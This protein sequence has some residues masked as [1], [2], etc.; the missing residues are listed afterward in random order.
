V[1]SEVDPNGTVSLT[2]ALQAFSLVVGP[3]PGVTPPAGPVGQVADGTFA[4]RWV[5]GYW[6]QLSTAQRTAIRRY[7]PEVGRETSAG[8]DSNAWLTGYEENTPP[9]AGPYQAAAEAAS[10]EIAGEIGHPLGIPI[11]VVIN[12][13]QV[14]T[15]PPDYA[16]TYVNGN[17]LNL[18]DPTGHRPMC[19]EDQCAMKYEGNGQWTTVIVA[20]P[21]SAAGQ[22]AAATAAANSNYLVV[23]GVTLPD[24][25]QY[26]KVAQAYSAMASKQASEINSSGISDELAVLYMTCISHGTDLKNLASSLCGSQ[27]TT[28]LASLWTV[29]LSMTV[30]VP[31]LQRSEIDAGLAAGVS[32]DLDVWAP[33]A[34]ANA[35]TSALDTAQNFASK[36]AVASARGTQTLSGW[37]GDPE[38]V[39][40]VSPQ[41]VMEFAEQ[42]GFQFR[43]AG[44]MDNGIPGSYYA[45]HAEPQMAIAEPNAPV[46]VNKPVCGSCQDFYQALADYTQTTQII[47]DPFRTF[48]FEPTEA[49]PDE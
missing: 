31:A 44:G 19:G 18:S 4:V 38:G 14:I 9:P 17:P 43:Q 39:T 30:G 5:L 42:M 22:A 40:R 7:L 16:Y 27:L 28:S 11:S 34:Q 25:P 10:A 41:E 36:K 46:V 2:T 33:L 24:T 35:M 8:S 26:E 29:S 1:L 20:G 49:D 21:D 37:G 32:E 3:L 45:S 15:T 47:T 12:P 48:I 23:A 6:R 13:T